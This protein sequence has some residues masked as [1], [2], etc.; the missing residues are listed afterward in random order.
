[1]GRGQFKRQIIRTFTVAVRR[2]YSRPFS[3]QNTMGAGSSG[4][5]SAS[6]WI[7]AVGLSQGSTDAGGRHL[8]SPLIP[9]RWAG[10]TEGMEGRPCLFSL[11]GKYLFSG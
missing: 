9:K 4:A 6:P 5:C 1:M 2:V 3:P 8:K 7:H 10:G 11:L